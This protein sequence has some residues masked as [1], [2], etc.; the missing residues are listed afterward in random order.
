MVRGFVALGLR[1]WSKIHSM[2]KTIG[3]R[4]A[5]CRGC[6]GK[7]GLLQLSNLCVRVSLAPFSVLSTASWSFTSVGAPT[8]APVRKNEEG[9]R[10][11]NRSYLLLDSAHL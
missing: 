11:S 4:Q 10:K 1:Q 6:E 5:S 7:I 8:V 2:A 9:V 3:Q